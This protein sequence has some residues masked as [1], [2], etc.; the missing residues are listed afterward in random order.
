MDSHQG[1]GFAFD[2]N[3]DFSNVFAKPNEDETSNSFFFGGDEG[4]D[5]TVMDPIMNA[6]SMPQGLNLDNTTGSTSVWDGQLT[7]EMQNTLNTF[8][9]TPTHS[10]DSMY[11]PNFSTA[12]G[13]RPLQLDAQDL[14]H[15]KRHEPLGDL[16]LFSPMTGAATTSSWPLDAQLT[17]AT[18]IEFGISDEAADMCAM[19][20]NK[21]AILP[22]D[23]H[24]DSLSQ[25]TGEPAEA[26][27]HW[28]GR[29][30]KQGM[31][32]SDSAY[33][34]QTGLQF[35]DQF[36]NNH[37]TGLAQVPQL[38][39]EE[40]IQ[41]S[42]TT[43]D[44]PTERENTT[45][46][47]SANA[48]RGGKKSRCTP[49]DD[50]TLL[51]RDSSKIYQCTRKC[52]KR[53]GRKCDWKRNEEEGY[54]CKSWVCSLCTNSGVENVKPCF[55]KY[56][57]AQ[58]FR[59]IHP[60]VNCEAYEEA[61]VVCSETEF[62]R[63]CGF[64]THRFTSRQERIDHI[65]EHFKQGKCMLDWSDS[66]EGSSADNTDNDDDDRP[67][68]DDDDNSGPSHQPPSRDPRGGLGS[69]YYGGS[70][71]GGH[72]DGGNGSDGSQ[73]GY[74][75]FQLS[76][77]DGGESGSQCYYA[78]QQTKTI[79]LLRDTQQ[80]TRCSSEPLQQRPA[81]DASEVGGFPLQSK[82][83]APKGYHAQ[84]LAGDALAR[85]L[86]TQDKIDT[87][88]HAYAPDIPDDRPPSETAVTEAVPNWLDVLRKRGRIS[89]TTISH[90]ASE[91][92]ESTQKTSDCS[93]LV[94]ENARAKTATPMF[95][96]GSK[97]DKSKLTQLDVDELF[98]RGSS[99][100]KQSI[101]RSCHLT[102]DSKVLQTIPP[103]SQSFLS[104]R[105]LGS[106]GFSTVD[107]VV[108]RDTALRLGRKTLKNRGPA[109]ID[110]LWKEVDVLQKLR[111][112][113]VI[114]FLGAYS[115]G[116]KMSI[117][118]SPIADTTLSLWLDRFSTEKPCA[119]LGQ[120]I[121]R[122][123]GCL[124]SS[125][126]YLHEQRPIVKHLDIK[127]QNILI[128]EGE[129]EFPHVVLCDFGI[130]ASEELSGP[131]Q[132]LTYQ[133]VAPEIFAGSTRRAAADIWSLGCVFAEMASVS[134]A[135]SNSK[136]STLRREFSGRT[137]K[138]YWQDVAGLQERLTVLH[139]GASSDTEKMV[140]RTLKTML[141]SQPN[142]RPDAASLTLAFTP[143]PCCLSWPN[144]KA[145]YPGP[146]DE[147][148]S[149]EMLVQEDGTDYCAQ[150]QRAC[151]HPKPSQGLDSAKTWLE[152]CSHSHEACRHTPQ[153]GN[154]IL[155]A[156]LLDISPNDDERC[157][158]VVDS[159]SIVPLARSVKYVAL[160]HFWNDTQATLTTDKL[161]ATGTSVQLSSLSDALNTAIA[162]A[163]SLGYRYV[164][165]DSLCVLQD[166]E[167]DKQVECANMASVY[168]NAALTLI[169]DSVDHGLEAFRQSL[170]NAE[171]G[172]A[173]DTR[174]WVLQERLL[175]HRF[176]HIGQEQM[177]WECNSLKASETFPEG[178][179]LLVWEKAH[180]KT[181]IPT[182]TQAILAE[183]ANAKSRSGAETAA[184]LANGNRPRQPFRIRDCQWIRKEGDGIGDSMEAA[185]TMLVLHDA[186][187][188]IATQLNESSA[189]NDKNDYHAD[190]VATSTHISNATTTLINE[191]MGNFPVFT[192]STCGDA[193]RRRANGKDPT[194]I[195]PK[196]TPTP[197]QA[198]L[199]ESHEE[200]SMSAPTTDL[201][202]PSGRCDIRSSGQLDQHGYDSVAINANAKDAN[203]NGNLMS[204]SHT[205]GT[206]L[207]EV[208][209]AARNGKV[210]NGSDGAQVEE[211]SSA[212]EVHEG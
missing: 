182:V 176:L 132:P 146:Q 159:T 144:D 70:N 157:V 201:L 113:H 178:L 100:L 62:P 153:P 12:L 59:N 80:R 22:S 204:R 147:L 65:A 160:S 122:M 148:T 27:R 35:S 171:S 40:S 115:Q 121:T 82:L 151:K 119:N 172:F 97:L 181:E 197:T 131:N 16:T 9:P 107:E 189:A 120:I 73:G 98:P 57:F 56:H 124:V 102:S 143:A 165:T 26:I 63:R 179:P 104:V 44:L 166:N 177:Y 5:T 190:V 87:Q 46:T 45:V 54:P 41:E 90:V 30:M 158:R 93:L 168:R 116:D 76:Q 141:R 58:H 55:R 48:L 43:P 184:V 198:S 155:P 78:Q 24:I 162:T 3:M 61:S 72:T 161:Q 99:R 50:L 101:Q 91:K 74:F 170:S 111:H 205:N 71:G 188:S 66:D 20:F 180:S 92:A 173:W 186:A 134:Y 202:K 109:A 39:L 15:A 19:W 156:R 69:K 33:K 14:P 42:I 105:L 212:D 2:M 84:T 203:G 67:S 169:L 207:E 8:P 208:P 10:F 152:E 164:W 53:Y 209:S 86:S 138:Y 211:F 38:P 7:P 150:L 192:T 185:Q 85:P 137:G 175:S 17:P 81:A 193:D 95:R 112:P 36:W 167:H 88:K 11:Q 200:R 196:P 210:M 128:V 174:G 64:C 32:T 142:D 163:Q 106:G 139:D 140:V 187:A 117:L 13:K 103:N 133:Y 129:A 89:T 47:Q 37:S 195:T 110:D 154:K 183:K 77:L 75:Q 25:L 68:D 4:I 51:S 49:T 31:N 79:D 1:A 23:R 28:F 83:G 127:P 136:W 60:G 123:F 130:S 149:V 206:Q 29:L 96:S 191:K 21:Y 52:G 126:R 34:S 114:R 199:H 6:F 135:Q 118:L 145:S 194:I 94:C 18:S 125:V 108:H